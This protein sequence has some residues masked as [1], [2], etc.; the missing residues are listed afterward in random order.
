MMTRKCVHGRGRDCQNELSVG[1]TEK[2][3]P[4]Q[5]LYMGQ[6]TMLITEEQSLQRP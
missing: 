5:N 2:A 4:E 6:L 3:T 1:P